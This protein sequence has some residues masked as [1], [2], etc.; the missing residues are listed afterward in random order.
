MGGLWE[1][2]GGMSGEKLG[3]MRL[4]LG[5]EVRLLGYGMGINNNEPLV[6]RSSLC[7]RDDRIFT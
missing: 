3:D 2:C 4:V 5:V 1:S 6:T 7:L